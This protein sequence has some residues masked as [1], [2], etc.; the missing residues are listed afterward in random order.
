SIVYAPLL[1][2]EG[3]ALD[4]VELLLVPAL[5]VLNGLFVA[6]EFALIAVRKTQIEELVRQGRKGAKHAEAA[7]SRLD[8]S[9]AATQLGITLA[10]LGLGWIG[11]PALAHLLVPLFQDIPGSWSLVASHSAATVL[12]FFLI[13]FMHVS[14][15]E[16]IPKNL[17][18]QSPV[19]A[20]LW[21]A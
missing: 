6:A 4:I 15:G 13:T 18:L 2:A 12:A 19:G 17:A 9:I 1:A 21:L 16:L 14:F 8:R 7:I 20:A 5:V 11:E 10:S 3:L